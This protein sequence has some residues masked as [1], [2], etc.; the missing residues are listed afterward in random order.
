MSGILHKSLSKLAQR[1]TVTAGRRWFHAW[2][3]V[4]S[5]YQPGPWSADYFHEAHNDY[6]QVLAETGAIGFGLLAWF[7]IAGG[8]QIVRGMKKVSKKNLPLMAGILAALG[9][10]AFH[11][12]FDFNLKIPANAFLFTVL[13]AL[14]LRMAKGREQGAGSWEQEAWR[15]EVRS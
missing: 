4:F 10:M 1:G 2:P 12:W 15:P 7:F 3:E 13:F 6:V 11:E 8:K 14:G 9:V 5:R